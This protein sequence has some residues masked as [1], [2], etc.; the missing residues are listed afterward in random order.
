LIPF[1]SLPVTRVDWSIEALT[2]ALKAG[3]KGVGEVAFYR[4]KMTSRDLVSLKPLLTLMEEKGSLCFT[5]M[6]GGT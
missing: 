1:I 4:R 5:P 6:K 3:A 2:E